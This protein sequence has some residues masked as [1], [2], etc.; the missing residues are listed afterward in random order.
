MG[1]PY[2]ISLI[3]PA[4]HKA[5]ADKLAQALGHAP[6]G[7]PTFVAELSSDGVN[8]THYGCHTYAQQAFVDLLTAASQGTLP[9]VPWADYGLTEQDV[10]EVLQALTARVAGGT[11]ADTWPAAKEAAGVNALDSSEPL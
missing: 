6:P 1:F 5:D 10:A 11:V 7:V 4:A 8:V 3:V 2:S 9:P